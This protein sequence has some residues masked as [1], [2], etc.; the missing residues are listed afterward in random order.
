M[1]SMILRKGGERVGKGDYWNIETSE[2]VHMDAEGM[3]P[4]SEKSKF[5]KFHPVVLL[6]LAPALGLMYA[7]FLPLIGM[8]MF[9]QVMARKA[10]SMARPSMAKEAGFNWQPSESYLAGRK[11]AKKGEDKSAKKEEPPKKE[12]SN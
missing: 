10:M 2:R 11:D 8:V 4:G 6:V 7:T 5:A 12:E 1:I 3:L 9:V